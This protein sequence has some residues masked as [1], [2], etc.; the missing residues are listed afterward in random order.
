M[1]DIL[2]KKELWYILYAERD[3]REEIFDIYQSVGND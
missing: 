1:I 2:N 3:N